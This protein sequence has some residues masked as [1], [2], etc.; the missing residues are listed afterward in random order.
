MCPG[1]RPGH[2]R[3]S[4]RRSSQPKARQRLRQRPQQR[5][6]RKS[7]RRG[8]GRRQARLPRPPSRSG[9]RPPRS[10]VRGPAGACKPPGRPHIRPCERPSHRAV[11]GWCSLAALRVA[12]MPIASPARSRGR[13]FACRSPPHAPG[14]APSGGSAPGRRTIVQGR[15]AWPPGCAGWGIGASSCRYGDVPGGSDFSRPPV[16]E[17]TYRGGR[18]LVQS[19]APALGSFL[20]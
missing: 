14:R 2:R 10:T 1:C 11:A 7:P 6:P 15:C 17:I 4:E 18:A 3:P 19:A 5:A 16:L 9:A 13:A 8:R 20:L 12:A